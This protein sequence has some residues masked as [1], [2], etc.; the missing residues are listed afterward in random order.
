M[1]SNTVPG[2]RFV[3]TLASSEFSQDRFSSYLAACDQMLLNS[4]LIVNHWKSH[5]TNPSASGVLHTEILHW[6]CHAGHRTLCYSLTQAKRKQD[7]A[8][9]FLHTFYRSARSTCRCSSCLRQICLINKLIGTSLIWFK[10]YCL[11]NR[12]WSNALLAIYLCVNSIWSL[13]YSI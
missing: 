4:Y 11:E 8:Q 6:S 10:H 2:V 1:I 12:T 7:A 9:R 13:K 5:L 3:R